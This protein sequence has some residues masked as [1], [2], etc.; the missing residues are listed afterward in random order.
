MTLMGLA[1]LS[2]GLLL[3][4]AI[5]VVKIVA[6]LIVLSMGI[7]MLLRPKGMSFKVEYLSMRLAQR[8]FSFYLYGFL[9]GPFALTCSLPIFI[10]LFSIPL[11]TGALANGLIAY[12]AFGLGISVPF[13][14]ISFLAHEVRGRLSR[15]FVEKQGFINRLSGIVLMLLELYLFISSCLG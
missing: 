14:V 2:L 12:L 10:A 7:V 15:V 8:M 9:Y 4:T 1:F 6:S 5:P 13:I 11:S 3:T